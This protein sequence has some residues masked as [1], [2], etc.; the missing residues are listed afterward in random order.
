IVSTGSTAATIR[1]AGHPVTDVAEVTGFAEALDGRVKTLHPAV[2][3]GLLADLR[4]EDHRRQLGELGFAPFEL[5]VVNLYPFEQTV[6]AGKPAADVIENIDIGGPSMV[7]A[8]AKNHA[9]AAIVVSPSRY[10]E[11][12]AAV[13][14]GGTTLELRRTLATEAFVHTA[15]YDAAVANW[16]L[17]Q[18]DAHWDADT[19][20]QTEAS[21][22][23]AN[24]IDSIF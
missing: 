2:H 1:D 16:F 22:G 14:A 3:S 7:R 10:D 11:V 15:Q 6:A 4:L 12:I 5:V 17:D 13:E 23:P 18:E 19:A 9:N 21:E 8:A 24:D 20:E